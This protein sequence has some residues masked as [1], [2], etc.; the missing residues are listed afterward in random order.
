MIEDQNGRK[1]EARR[2][3]EKL[4]RMREYGSSHTLAKEYLKRS[5]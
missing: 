2:N 5:E 3:Y 4:L 1:E